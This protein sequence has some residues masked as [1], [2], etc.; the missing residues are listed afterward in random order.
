MAMKPTYEALEQRVKE[1]EEEAAKRERAVQNLKSIQWLLAKSVASEHVRDKRY[2]QPYG[3]LVEL[4]AERIL[5]DS[6]G[7]S[8]LADIVRD[9]I[10]L[11]DTSAAI[12]ERNGDYALGIFPSSWCRILDQAS[13][14]L[15][16]TEDNAEAL[17]SGKWHCHESCWSE[18]SKVSIETGRPVDIECRG[19]IRL[20]AIPIWAGTEIVGSI[21]F[22]YGDPPRD[23]E[24]LDEIGRRFGISAEELIEHA[25]AYQSRPTFMIDLAKSRLATSA[26]L[27]GEIVE[28]KQAEETIKRERDFTSAVLSVEGALVVVLDKEGRIVR[29]N[30][31]C[32]KLTGYSFQ[33]VE[34]GHV[35]DLFLIKEEVEPV[36]AVFED[37]RSG[38][39]P[40]EHENYWLTK[41]GSRRLISWSNTAILD[42]EGSVEHVIGT[43]IDITD[44]KQAEEALRESE[45][46]Y[47][48]I[49][50]TAQEGIWV[51]DTDAK[52][53]YVNQRLAD[54]RTTFLLQEWAKTLKGP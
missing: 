52:V 33:E 54:M 4:N 12:Y 50:N 42:R 10:D 20:Y 28:R 14:A 48:R 31:A 23:P 15:C 13:R 46:R 18:A 32:E 27:I 49:V 2:T 26:S 17:K 8:V 53:T 35:W 37:L 43:G 40:N 24:K 19:G 21:N 47:R 11:L 25:E 5:L 1:L 6:V 45:E 22:G 41:D 34:G 44:S 16:K 51:V 36:K 38:Q 30:K 39:F 7:E 29:F 3:N 9:Y